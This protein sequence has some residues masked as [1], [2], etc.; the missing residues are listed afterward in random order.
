MI[1]ATPAP[2]TEIAISLPE[3]ARRIGISRATI[4]N[5][6]AAGTLPTIKIGGRRVVRIAVLEQ[7]LLGR[8]QEAL[9]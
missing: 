8:E 4:W 7:F 9:R 3:A 5:L 2:E 6:A 1:T